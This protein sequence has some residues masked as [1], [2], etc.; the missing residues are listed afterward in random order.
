MKQ[1]YKNSIRTKKLLKDTFLKLASKKNID[2]ITIKEITDECNLTRNTFY[3]H[4][5]DIY[6][7]LEDLQKE[8]LNELELALENGKKNHIIKAPIP[9]LN[10]VADNIEKN[11]DKYLILFSIKGSDVFLDKIK[12]IFLHHVIDGTDILKFKKQNEFLLF[13]EILTSG[14]IDLFKK[15]LNKERNIEIRNIVEEINK[16]YLNGINLY[17]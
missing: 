16:I 6:D 17:L 9:F 12:T 14:A 10:E 13:L 11:K 2:K 4:F 7:L 15:S 8:V 1:T 5:I 3:L